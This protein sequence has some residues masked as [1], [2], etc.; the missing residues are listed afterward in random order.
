[1]RERKDEC[2][3]VSLRDVE[4]TLTILDWFKQQEANITSVILNRLYPSAGNHIDRM[5]PM[6]NLILAL[7]VSYY[8][9]LDE[10]RRDYEDAMQDCLEVINL[11]SNCINDTFIMRLIEKKI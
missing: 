5:A 7:G 9:R 1:M 11:I 3:F 10:Q 8:V 4:R 2:S 6:I